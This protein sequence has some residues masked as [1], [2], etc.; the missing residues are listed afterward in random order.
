MKWSFRPKHNSWYSYDIIKC[1][2]LSQSQPL[3]DREEI[4]ENSKKKKKEDILLLELC[5]HYHNK[6]KY[7]GRSFK[8]LK[9]CYSRHLEI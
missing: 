1:L 9:F 7:Y 3:L 8:A 4:K 2:L 6:A 5:L